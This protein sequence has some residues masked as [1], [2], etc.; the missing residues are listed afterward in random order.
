M[1]ISVPVSIAVYLRFESLPGAIG[2]F[3]VGVLLDLDHCLDYIVYSRFRSVSLK[4]F[5]Q[6]CYNTKL[7]PLSLVLHSY[8]IIPL[9]FVAGFL[10]GWNNLTI[11]ILTGFSLHIILDQLTNKTKFAQ[12]PLFYFFAY[13]MSKGFRKELLIGRRNTSPPASSPN[14]PCSPFSK[15]GR[16]D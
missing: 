15:G 1:A 9:L 2:C 3:I 6:T 8:E 10:T 7:S 12:S 5:F 11:G 4:K 13:R 14:P 16:E